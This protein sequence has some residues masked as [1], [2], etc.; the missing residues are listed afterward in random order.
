MKN[1]AWEGGGGGHTKHVLP[2]VWHTTG[3]TSLSREWKAAALKITKRKWKSCGDEREKEYEQRN[4][5]VASG[6]SARANEDL[7]FNVNPL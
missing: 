3:V 7:R 2:P 6:L 1:R 4:K 5:E